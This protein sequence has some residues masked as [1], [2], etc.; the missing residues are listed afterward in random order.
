MLWVSAI[1]RNLLWILSCICAQRT[2]LPLLYLVF[3]RGVKHSEDFPLCQNL[4]SCETKFTVFCRCIVNWFRST[5]GFW[6]VER[7][8]QLKSGLNLS[9][10]LV[11]YK[12][13]WWH[14]TLWYTMVIRKWYLEREEEIHICQ[15]TLGFSFWSQRDWLSL[16]QAPFLTYP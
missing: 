2:G 3:K 15:C 16:T 12:A 10:S 13:G 14:G 7:A 1:Q 4:L 6:C 8:V 9:W 5:P 11:S